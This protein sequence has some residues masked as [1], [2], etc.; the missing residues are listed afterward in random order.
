[1]RGRDIVPFNCWN[2]TIGGK[3]C[4]N[5]RCWNSKYRKPL[6][7]HR[8]GRIQLLDALCGFS[9]TLLCFRCQFPSRT[10]HEPYHTPDWPF[11]LSVRNNFTYT[12]ARTI[13]WASSTPLP[14]LRNI[15]SQFQSTPSLLWMGLLWETRVSRCQ[16]FGTWGA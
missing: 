16:I 9:L 8:L 2:K 15:R 1:M 5:P 12:R 11:A 13:E 14:R 4:T 3:T 7:V 10:F 6:V